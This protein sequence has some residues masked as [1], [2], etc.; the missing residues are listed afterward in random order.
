MNAGDFD[1]TL[2]A[3]GTLHLAIGSSCEEAPMMSIPLN[4]CQSSLFL[5]RASKEPKL[6]LEAVRPMI[7]TTIKARD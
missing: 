7:E 3:M 2:V 1:R 4:F 5:K 6:N